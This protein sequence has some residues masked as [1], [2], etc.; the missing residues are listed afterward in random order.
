MQTHPPLW[1]Q[2]EWVSAGD[3]GKCCWEAELDGK[4]GSNTSAAASASSV[5]PPPPS[6]P[7]SIFTQS[8][9]GLPARPHLWTPQSLS[10]VIVVCNAHTLNIIPGPLLN[11]MEVVEVS[12]KVSEE[13]ASI[14]F[15]YLCQ[16]S[17][18]VG[19]IAAVNV[20]VDL[21]AIDVLIKVLFEGQQVFLSI[22]Y[23]SSFIFTAP[24]TPS[25]SPSMLATAFM[26]ATTHAHAHAHIWRH[27]AHRYP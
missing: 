21:E 9:R 11:R 25:L 16:Q 4:E 13:K 2:A 23:I 7:G 27:E 3:V 18:E 20:K 22:R 12:G 10:R 24:S 1:V 6:N 17:K 19:G 26:T 5:S 15:T 8:V 14:A